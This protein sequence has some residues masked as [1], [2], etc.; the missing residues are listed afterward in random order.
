LCKDCERYE[1]G[2]DFRNKPKI[3]AFNRRAINEFGL[4]ERFKTLPRTGGLNAQENKMLWAFQIISD[5]IAK[6]NK[7]K[8]EELRDKWQNKVS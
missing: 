5:E 1:K 3:T 8:E 6:I 4:C 2:C 7:G